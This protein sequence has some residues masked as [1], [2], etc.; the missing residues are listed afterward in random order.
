ML[1]MENIM[2]KLQQLLIVSNYTIDVNY[3]DSYFDFISKC[4]VDVLTEY[5]EKHHILPRSLFPELIKDRSNIVPLKPR[6]HFLAHYYL[7]KLIKSKETVFAF[8]QM[9]R[10]LKKFKT[11]ISD[12][13][14]LSLLYEE[15]RTE[16]SQIISEQNKNWFDKLPEEKQIAVRNQMSKR[17]KGKVPVKWPDG[18]TGVIDNTHPDYINGI[19]IPIQTGTKRSAKAIENLKRANS[20]AAKGKP[21]HDP[22]TKQTKY[23]HEGCQ[24]ADWIK[25]TPP[26]ENS[27]KKGAKWYHNPI[28]KE[29]GKYYENEIPVGWIHGRI[30][31][32][33]NGNPN[34]AKRLNIDPSLE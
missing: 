23:F 10:V 11:A 5:H 34:W 30:N 16:L 4:S 24:P 3:I 8:N 14:S 29:Q 20:A 6:D 22:I 26:G 9:K 25:G 28:T 32:G 2:N 7:A 21:W 18:T 17:F 27:G 1:D 12:V 19:A 13:D 31:F 33:A 15:F